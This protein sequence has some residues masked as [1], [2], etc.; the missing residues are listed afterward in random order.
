MSLLPCPACSRHVRKS[1][2]GCPFC[3]ASLALASEPERPQPAQRLGRAATFAFA[4]AIGTSVA[5]CSGG[6]TPADSGI[7]PAYGAPADTGVDAA[8]LAM[9][10]GPP[11]DAGTDGGGPAPAYGAP[12]FDAGTD[13]GSSAALYGA[14]P[15]PDSGA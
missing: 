1:E 13:T 2:S 3:G 5:A 4:A 10:G 9:Y 7:A 11:Q 8:I 14:V 6:T 15:A 12:A